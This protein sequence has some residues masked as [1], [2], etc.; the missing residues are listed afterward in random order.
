MQISFLAGA[1]FSKWS[2][3]LPLVSGLF[4]F[5]VHADNEKEEK[6][7]V[8]LQRRYN[9]WLQEHPN[10]NNEAF[11]ASAQTAE[12]KFNLVNWY[13]TRRLTEPFIIES[14]RRYTWYINSYHARTHHGIVRAQS[15]LT[16]LQRVGR[17][18]VI[19][20]NYDMVIEYSLGTR[21]FN[22]GVLN[23]NIGWSP[24]PYPQPVRLTGNVSIAKLHGSLSWGP[25][26]KR[27]D[28]RYGL[29]GKCL[30]VPPTASKSPQSVLAE[31][32]LVAER[33]LRQSRVLVVMGF[34]FNDYDQEIRQFIAK[35]AA[36]IPKVVFVD[37]SDIRPRVRSLFIE[38]ELIYIDA[39]SED[40]PRQLYE[41]VA[42]GHK[43]ARGDWSEPIQGN[44][45]L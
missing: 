42:E 8:R 20:T 18:G 28:L 2:C 1:G 35:R 14:G 39:R 17:L 23:E 29:T 26:G 43:V 40:L 10:E 13:I 9:Q 7:F 12:G 19:T 32:W 38:K 15:I 31:Q 45:P 5:H 34:A 36:N 24:Y 25:D 22:Y 21:N 33:I 6:R 3:D 4:D 27:P 44:L 30:I 41:A 37:V 11:V 16:A